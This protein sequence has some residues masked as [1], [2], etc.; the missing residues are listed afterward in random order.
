MDETGASVVIKIQV[1]DEATQ[2]LGRVRKSLGRTGDEAEKA[3][4]KTS[5]FG[6]GLGGLKRMG[7]LAQAGV[8]GLAVGVKGAAAAFTAAIAAGAALV[9]VTDKL[10]D[11]WGEQTQA[12]GGAA[13]A[14][15]RVGLEGDALSNELERI[16]QLAG[17]MSLATMFGDEDIFKAVGT[18]TKL[19]GDARIE[20]E[21]L[22]LILGI[23]AG[24]QKEA[25]EAAEIYAKA[26][27]GDIGPLKDLTSLT[28]TQEKELNA[29][30]GTEEQA[31]LVTEILAAQ[32]AGLAQEVDPTANAVKNLADSFGDTQQAMGGVISSSGVIAPIMDALT[33]AFRM[34]EAAVYDNSEQIQQWIVSAVLTALD[35]IADFNQL[36]LDNADTIGGVTTVAM[37]FGQVL[38]ILVNTVTL[39]AQTLRTALSASLAGVAEGFA[40]VL[41]GAEAMAKAVGDTGLAKEFRIAAGAAREMADD[42]AGDALKGLEG[43]KKEAIEATEKFDAFGDIITSTEERAALARRGLE[44]TRDNIKAL[45]LEIE[46]AGE[47]IKPVTSTT[48]K[49]SG[50]TVL[51]AQTTA[52]STAALDKTA[53]ATKEIAEAEE[54]RVVMAI[55]IAMARQNE[56]RASEALAY[57]MRDVL[58]SVQGMSTGIGELDA[59]AGSMARLADAAEQAKEA[60]RARGVAAAAAAFG[61]ADAT[62][63]ATAAKEQSTAAELARASAVAATGQAVASAAGALGASAQT[64]AAIQAAFNAAAAVSAGASLYVTGN[65]AFGVAAAQYAVSAGL[66]AAVA[67][68]MGAPSASSASTGAGAAGASSTPSVSANADAGR[69]ATLQAEALADVLEERRAG[70]T[71]YNVTIRDSVVS[72]EKEAVRLLNR[73]LRQTS[74]T[75]RLGGA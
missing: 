58:D 61:D 27:K 20:T 15:Q 38:G 44:A 67:G 26:M 65:P 60:E 62:E 5:V 49:R 50:K 42:L 74:Q 7:G 32:Y 40:V 51:P 63:E 1:D 30:V 9:A 39:I 24:T 68:G 41:D 70:D 18:Y 71:V 17:E 33:G 8:T 29:L 35:T 53:K 12:V 14:L 2:G 46:K 37:L 64:E 36:L 72:S 25:A 73:G 22:D 66:Y 55:D 54:R 11:A 10:L 56:A 28:V 48:I 19:S 69:F 16:N 13:S 57:S 75:L 59:L 34:I 31:A 43:I 52:D 6:K 3:G 4:K 47:N 23:A 45:R 21:Q